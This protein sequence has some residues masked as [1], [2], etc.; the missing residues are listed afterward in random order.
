MSKINIILYCDKCRACLCGVSS[1]LTLGQFEEGVT[2]LYVQ[3]CE[4]CIEEV[5]DKAFADG[6]LDRQLS[7]QTDLAQED[8]LTISYS[9]DNSGNYTAFAVA[10]WNGTHVEMSTND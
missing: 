1:E 10:E 5:R 6:Q 7:I 8:T 4:A 2:D 9:T 3:L